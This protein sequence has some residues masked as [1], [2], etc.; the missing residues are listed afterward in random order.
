MNWL[1]NLFYKYKV[2]NPT[3]TLYQSFD[4]GQSA[5]MMEGPWTIFGN[6]QAGLDWEAAPLPVIGSKPANYFEDDGLE[7]YQQK[8]YGQLQ[9]H[10]GSDQ[11]A[12]RQQLALG[13]RRPRR[14][15]APVAPAPQRLRH[16]RHQR[17]PARSTGSP[18]STG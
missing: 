1:L 3:T 14:H 11:V 15:A 2:I 5:M 8:S 12:V 9:A 18:T 4:T 7:V 13:H 10:H 6:N 16:H 17:L